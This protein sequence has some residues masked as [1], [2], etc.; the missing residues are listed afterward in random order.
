MIAFFAFMA[1]AVWLDY[2]KK[3]EERE[4]IHRERM[5][6]L[7]LGLPL[8]DPEI[9][10]A[11]AYAHAAWAAALVGIL[12]PVAVLALTFAGTIVAVATRQPGGNIAG[13]LIVA[14]SIAAVLV[15]VPVVRSLGVIRQLPRPTPD[16][17]PRTPDLEKR[18]SVSSTRIQE[19]SL[20]L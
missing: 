1:L 3:K 13:P 9:E 8:L 17:P 20:E 12:V 16:A 18:A 7:E 10:R 14:W 4:A 15:L 11:R 19:K 5:K 2:R 6:S